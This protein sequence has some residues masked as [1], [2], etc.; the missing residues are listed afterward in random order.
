MH[1]EERD[2]V[3]YIRA[4]VHE[5]TGRNVDLIAIVDMLAGVTHVV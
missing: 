1:I 3:A 4:N 5:L 2:L